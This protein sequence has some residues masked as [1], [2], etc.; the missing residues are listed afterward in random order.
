M[1][2]LHTSRRLGAAL[3][4]GLCLLVEP[5]IA[6]A[7]PSPSP[8][9]A[10]SGASGAAP[11]AGRLLPGVLEI[12]LASGGMVRGWIPQGYPTLDI[13]TEGYATWFADLS[14][15]IGDLFRIHRAYYESNG[16]VPPT[17]TSATL[18]DASQG[19]S[20]AYALL[21]L[22]GGLKLGRS[23]DWEIAV[24]HTREVFRITVTPT[25]PT[26]F[27]AYD[28]VGAGHADISTL[29]LVTSPISSVTAFESTSVGAMVELGKNSPI[30]GEGFL[31]L[32]YTRYQ[33]PYM[34]RFGDTF[35]PDYLFGL[36]TKICG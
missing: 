26:H 8:E 16:L 14:V 13:S 25:Q 21:L 32:A 17:S 22:M 10:S 12:D 23:S 28:S 15:N 30:G 31:G 5:G 11:P 6:E 3:A 19:S 1:R 33:K 9:P 2:S 18:A 24:R 36:V 35:I 34:F 29:P 7:A 27:V 4:A 20:L